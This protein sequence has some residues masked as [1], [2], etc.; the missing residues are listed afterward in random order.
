MTRLIIIYLYYFIDKNKEG[1][2]SNDFFVVGLGDVVDADLGFVY[3]VWIID[4]VPIRTML[5]SSI[6]N[7]SQSWNYLVA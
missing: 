3:V 6:E 5:D 2:N 4:S 1:I 7:Y